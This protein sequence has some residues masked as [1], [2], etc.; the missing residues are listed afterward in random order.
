VASVATGVSVPSSYTH[1]R[2]QTPAVTPHSMPGFCLYGAAGVIEGLGALPTAG[3]MP[4]TPSG[5]VVHSRGPRLAHLGHSCRLS[6]AIQRPQ[7]HEGSGLRFA[8][9]GPKAGRRVRLPL[10]TRASPE[11]A[12]RSTKRDNATRRS[13]GRGSPRRRQDPPSDRSRKQPF[14]LRRG[15]LL[16][17]PEARWMAEA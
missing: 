1:P 16:A 5:A 6:K 10:P 12:S 13:T 2:A 17:L 3:C 8:S 15:P 9:G 7:R 14:L 11:L 4:T